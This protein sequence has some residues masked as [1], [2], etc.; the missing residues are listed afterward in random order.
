LGKY[1][2]LRRI[3]M[4]EI[5]K[6][7][8]GVTV[9]LEKMPFVRS[10]SFGI[11]V[12]NGS[13]NESKDTNGISHFIEHM[14]F[15]GTKVRSA[16]QIAEEMDSIGGQL[17]AYT[18]KEYT[19]YYTRVLDTHFDTAINVLS[20]MYFN[21]VFDDKEIKKELNVIIEE[22]NMYEDSPDDLVYDKLQY[23][24]WKENSLSMPILGTEDVI[25]KF[26]HNTFIDYKN[27]NYRTDNTVIAVAGNFEKEKIID[28]INKYFGSWEEIPFDADNTNK[29]V[30]NPCIVKTKKDIEQIHL[31]ISFEGVCLATDDSYTLS[32]LN[33]IFGGGMSSRLF[34][35][36]REENGLAYSVYSYNSSYVD[37][38]LFSIYAGLNPNQLR[39]VIKFILE[40]INLLYKN[41]I[42]K[43][44]L[45]KA[46]EQIKSNFLLSLE[47]TL[48]RISSIGRGQLL[49][50]R[51]LTNDELIE[52]INNITI[53]KVYDLCYKIFNFDKM[54]VS[55]VGK[56]EDIDIKDMINCSL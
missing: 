6:L 10:I 7:K 29:V 40:E 1:I 56:V 42:T 20:D 43:E 11:F 48:N 28:E 2:K 21:S 27:K 44:E 24:V 53:D 46:K 19:C 55:V 41:K 25:S 32:V 51:V 45:Y 33:T 47:N 37:T 52:K 4:T 23:N 54:A 26:N 34:Q 17:N 13:R 18:T 22:I 30:F 15:K 38:G 39:D 16:R 50:N 49:L 35:K 9:V 12:K 3:N 14:I 36:I 5:I 31:C 8:N